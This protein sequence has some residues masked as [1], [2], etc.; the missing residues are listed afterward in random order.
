MITFLF[1]VLKNSN[2]QDQDCVSD[3][4]ISGSWR[5]LPSEGDSSETT[6]LILSSI[7]GNTYRM[8]TEEKLQ[9]YEKS[10]KLDSEVIYLFRGILSCL[11]NCF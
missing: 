10:R 11:L 8:Y 2:C 3:S 6:P 5:G 1:F 9:Y 7:E 4:G